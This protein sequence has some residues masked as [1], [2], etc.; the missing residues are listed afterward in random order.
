MSI[1]TRES[2]FE[3]Q[4]EEILIT[5]LE[6]EDI[7]N[8]EDVEQFQEEIYKNKELLISIGREFFN[9]LCEWNDTETFEKVMNK[10]AEQEEDE[11]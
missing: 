3:Y 6:G 7:Q 10:L 2:Q 9:K 4:A 8:L 1:S 5:A 11:E